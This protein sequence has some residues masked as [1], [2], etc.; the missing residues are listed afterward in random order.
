MID[1]RHLLSRRWAL[2]AFALALLLKAAM[3]MLASASAQAQGKTV[4][5]VCTVYGV[6]LV[7]LDDG[8]PTNAPA[9][10]AADHAA[11]HCALNALPALA[12]LDAPAVAVAPAALQVHD[13]SPPVARGAAPDA[14][15]RWVAGLHHGPPA[16]A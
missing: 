9:D 13:A 15:A 14:C 6:S 2:W 10:H 4:V 16:F 1:R 7:P 8:A 3:P 11:D 12:A 5:E